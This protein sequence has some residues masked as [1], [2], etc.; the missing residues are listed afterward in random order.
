MKRD[1]L[2]KGN[3]AKGTEDIGGWYLS[4][5]IDGIRCFWDGGVSRD[6]DITEVPWANTGKLK[7]DEVV[8]ATGLWSYYGNPIQAPDW[9]LNELPCCMLD[10]ELQCGRGNF[11]DV[12]SFVRKKKPVDEEWRQVQFSVFSSPQ[13]RQVFRDG[14]INHK[15]FT[16]DI[17]YDACEE[18]FEFYAPEDFA[19]LVTSTGADVSF[20][21]E[22]DF[23]NHWLD[24]ANPNIVSMLP[25]LR[26]PEDSEKAWEVVQQRAKNI[27]E[28]GG[29]GVVVRDGSVPWTPKRVRTVLKVKA[30]LDAEA[31]IVGAVTGEIGKTGKLHGKIGNFVVL[32]DGKIEFELAGFKD[33]TERVINCPVLK[34][35]ALDHPGERVPVGM[36]NKG[37]LY[38]NVGDEITFT[39]RELT[40]EG[41]P[42]E[43]RY[44]RPRPEGT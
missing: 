21:Q 37:A 10:G 36:L 20:K 28:A 14:E 35:W 16:K 2:M 39:Y 30:K 19:H 33:S 3:P 27:H 17:I 31:I 34:Q 40:R 7:E 25:Q 18:F 44:L 1:F 29:E 9:F 38:F 26:L 43:A 8:L 22:L 13:F 41:V 23:I 6:H 24:E 11:Q 42:K 5:K 32:Y 15:N 4:E 12:S